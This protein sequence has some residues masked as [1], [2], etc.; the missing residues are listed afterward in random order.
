LLDQQIIDTSGRKVVRVNDVDLT[1]QRTNGNVEL[2]ITQV[3]VGLPGA[4]RRLLQGIAPPRMIRGL[5]SR[6]P[7]KTIRWEFVNLV[8]PDPLRR[9][10]L[11]ITHEKLED[12]HPADLA[13]IV[14]ELSPA[15]RQ[16]II[17]S[18]DEETAAAVLAELDA[19]LTTQIVEKLDPEKAADILE[20]MAPDA[21]ADLLADLPR[22]TSEEVLE[23]MPTQE[24]E[25]VRE[26]LEFDPSTAGGMMNTDFVFV[27]DKSKRDEVVEWMKE[28][29]LNLD[30][31]D[32]IVLLNP[33][34]QLSGAVPVAR[35]LL[36]AADQS[37]GELKMEPL[38]SVTADADEKEVF[39]LF[40]KYNLRMLTVVDEEKRPIG[41]I[42]VDDVVSKLMK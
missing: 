9:L 31:L 5:Q 10:K 38:V 1:E 32:T 17:A 6:L 15:E 13:D 12:L 16:G 39:E 20:E 42:T 28:Q 14:E 41:T 18:L 7:A 35:L 24:A 19:R 3:D 34:A 27:G 23:E 11:R 33:D 30:Q 26:L 2:R 29:D 36:A 22:E 25:E 21:A 4:V 37:L 40:D 8:E